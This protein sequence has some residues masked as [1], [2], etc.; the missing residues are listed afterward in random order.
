MVWADDD[1]DGD[2]DGAAEGAGGSEGEAAS[3]PARGSDALS[4]RGD[5]VGYDEDT[6]SELWLAW[7]Q[8]GT[9]VVA[10]AAGSPGGAS[11]RPK[12]ARPAPY[13]NKLDAR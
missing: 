12:G 13:A 7:A 1:G 6:A 4:A 5:G 3:G 8:G 2:G 11:C 10:D 9:G